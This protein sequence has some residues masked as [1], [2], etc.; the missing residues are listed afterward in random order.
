[1]PAY[2]NE[3]NSDDKQKPIDEKI[4]NPGTQN[5]VID[6]K[7]NTLGLFSLII[8]IVSLLTLSCCGS[9]SIILAITAIITG[10]IARTENQDYATIGIILGAL[11]LILPLLLALFL[12]GFVFFTPFFGGFF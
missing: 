5:I 12:T 8:G 3:N 4:E 9:L 6:R 7:N 10:I 1:M 11:G 2:D